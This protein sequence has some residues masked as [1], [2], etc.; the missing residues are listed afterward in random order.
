MAV[1]LFLHIGGAVKHALID[2]DKTL[3]RMVPGLYESDRSSPL[4][5]V[6]A[7][8]VHAKKNA[9]ASKTL[10]FIAFVLAGCVAAGIYA[11]GTST[12]QATLTQTQE[13]GSAQWTVDHTK[14]SLVIEVTQN[15]APVT[16]QFKEWQAKIDFDPTR[17]DEARV[18]ARISLAS[19]D[20]GGT[21]QQAISA[22]FLNAAEHPIATF[23]SDRFVKTGESAY[24]A[25][26]EL[27]LS[28]VKKPFVLPFTLTIEDGKATMGA[29]AILKRLDFGVGQKGFANEDTVGFEV[30][31]L[32]SIEASNKS[33]VAGGS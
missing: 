3:H 18:E 23:A 10:A 6:A 22:G 29:Q 31:I 12:S 1:S 4:T 26:G 13:S 14:S 25:Q 32:I 19:L 20:L 30:K 27:D 33:D 9:L 2:R 24:E 7:P 28:G 5:S 15:K 8:A 11:S 17:L 16:G 21:S